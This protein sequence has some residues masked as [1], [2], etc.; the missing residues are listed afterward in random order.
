MSPG[1]PVV[2][3]RG[4]TTIVQIGRIRRGGSC[5]E[6]TGPSGYSHGA[7]ITSCATLKGHRLS[8]GRGGFRIPETP[9]AFEPTS[10]WEACSQAWL[11][12]G[13]SVR[14][15]EASAFRRWSFHSS[16]LQHLLIIASLGVDMEY[17]MRT[18]EMSFD[19]VSWACFN[20]FCN[21]YKQLVINKI[22]IN[23]QYKDWLNGIL[24]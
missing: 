10:R 16:P 18:T 3:L 19:D 22:D 1:G 13:L 8:R 4:N 15:S 2:R 6:E 9:S 14:H 21:E 17:F 11:G 12:K 23:F 5:Y 7:L 20:L 24:K